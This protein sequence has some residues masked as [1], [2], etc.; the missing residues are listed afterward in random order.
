VFSV[1]Y[2]HQFLSGGKPLAAMD[3]FGIPLALQLVGFGA[4]PGTSLDGQSL[5]R[6][7]IQFVVSSTRKIASMNPLDASLLP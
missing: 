5:L 7:A 4:I 6:V 1:E 2:N 3:L